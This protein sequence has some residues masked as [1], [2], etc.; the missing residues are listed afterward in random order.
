MGKENKR[1]NYGKQMLGSGKIRG[2]T[3]GIREWVEKRSGLAAE[4]RAWLEGSRG[5]ANGRVWNYEYFYI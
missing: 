5:L 1:I 3:E 4:S 2:W